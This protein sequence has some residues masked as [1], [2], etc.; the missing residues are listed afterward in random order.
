MNRFTLSWQ[1][2]C[3]DV[4]LGEDCYNIITTLNRDFNKDD[5]IFIFFE[6][7]FYFQVFE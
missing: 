7:N 4:P 1:S 3:I 6:W 2:I 5:L